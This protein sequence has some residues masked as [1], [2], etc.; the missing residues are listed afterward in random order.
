MHALAQLRRQFLQL[1]LIASG[2][3]DRRARAVQR[4]RHRRLQQHELGDADVAAQ[5][6]QPVAGVGA[7]CELDRAGVPA[8][9]WPVAWRTR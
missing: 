4:H 2:N 3:P 8:D 7:E 1:A 6:E 9:L 5:R